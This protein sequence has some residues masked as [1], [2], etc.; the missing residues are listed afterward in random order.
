MGH[1]AKYLIDEIEHELEL[2][3]AAQQGTKPRSLSRK[4]SMGGSMLV[5]RLKRS[6]A[7]Q[8]DMGSLAVSINILIKIM[9]FE[10]TAFLQVNSEIASSMPDLQWPPVFG[11]ISSMVSGVVNLDFATEH[12][13][14]NCT[15]GNNYCFRVMMMMLAILGFQ[16]AFPAC[17]AIVKLTPLRKM[18]AQQRLEQLVDRAYHGNAIVMMVLHPTI[19]KKLA[20]ILACRWY[21]G[22]N[23][24]MAAKTISCG[25]NTC[26]VTGIF[27]FFLYTVGIPVYV[28][29][30]L[31]QFASPEAKVK[32]GKSPMLARY[33]SRMGFICGK[34]EADFW[35]YELLE[36]TRK[37]MLMAVACELLPLSP[38]A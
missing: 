32:L 38:L 23:V 28:W 29:Y 25:D 5:D 14:A 20:S 4:M 8:V 2:G 11:E 12:G 27:F 7:S 19:S 18:V 36:M 37:T 24:V 3:M 34:F 6:K 33:K 31:R 10:L 30:S 17:I 21:N 22:E 26:L 16:L 13:E 15:L 9:I 1:C 35:Y